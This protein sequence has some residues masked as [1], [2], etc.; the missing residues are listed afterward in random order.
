MR[1]VSEKEADIKNHSSQEEDTRVKHLKSEICRENLEWLGRSLVC[2]TDTPSYLC[3]IAS[4]LNVGFPLCTK[5]CALSNFKFILTFQSIQEME[6]ILEQPLELEQWFS[7]I[8]KWDIYDISDSR[9]TWVEVFGIPPYGWK[10]ENF[11]KIAEM[12]GTFVCLGS[13]IEKPESFES[14][15]I[16]IDTNQ[17]NNIEG[18]FELD[19]ED[20]GYRVKA[21]EVKHVYKT[22]IKILPRM[23]IS[24]QVLKTLVLMVSLNNLQLKQPRLL[25]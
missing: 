18:G 13:D 4:S 23:M 11:K 22:L 1:Q 7:S 6:D 15:M 25:E 3:A 9:R 5:V 10:W 24:G 2:S 20:C 12:W 16:L 19:L 8:K 17:F 21:R 14:M